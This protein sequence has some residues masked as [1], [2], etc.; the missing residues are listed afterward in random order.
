MLAKCNIACSAT[1]GGLGEACDS[2][3]KS[4]YRW[5]FESIFATVFNPDVFAYRRWNENATLDEDLRVFPNSFTV[6]RFGICNVAWRDMS[7]DSGYGKLVTE[8]GCEQTNLHVW[9]KW[10]L[11]A[12]LLFWHV[13]CVLFVCGALQLHAAR[14][15][16]LSHNV[17]E[18]VAV[19][20]DEHDI[21]FHP[22]ELL[23]GL[24]RQ[25]SKNTQNPRISCL[26]H[27]YHFVCFYYR[28]RRQTRIQSKWI[29]FLVV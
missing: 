29:T 7:V 5:I 23:R 25:H 8:R 21:A 2:N 12:Y 26:R 22:T 3:G 6:D 10:Q 17:Y 28:R 20:C 14:V 24:N 1:G 18:W 15:N 13:W 9:C 11:K 27:I 16:R 4:S 19:D